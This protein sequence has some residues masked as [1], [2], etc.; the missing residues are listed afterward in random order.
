[1]MHRNVSR[2]RCL[3]CCPEELF[4]PEH[5]AILISLGYEVRIVPARR[6]ALKEFMAVKPSLL[7]VHHTFLP[8]FPYRLIQLFKMS[9]RTPAVLLMAE[10][11]T[12][13]WGYLHLK[14][15]A[16]FEFL[17]TPLRSEDLALGVKLATQHLR[18]TRH[19]LF[20]RDLTV[21]TAMALPVFLF[22]IYLI[23]RYGY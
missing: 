21:Q 3:V 10:N 23:I 1:M 11:M 15:E 5:A 6:R 7:I 18:D 9:H 17:G 19:K 22:L 14:N 20:V 12:R 16:D 2:E 8:T 4:T 13:V